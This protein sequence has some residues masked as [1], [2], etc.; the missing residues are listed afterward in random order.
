MENNDWYALSSWCYFVN[1]FLKEKFH[2]MP[3]RTLQAFPI[4][5]FQKSALTNNKR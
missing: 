4:E 3:K 5:E 2:K 1:L